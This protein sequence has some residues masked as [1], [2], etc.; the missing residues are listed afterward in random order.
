MAAVDRLGQKSAA[1]NGC[2]EAES[3]GE[4]ANGETSH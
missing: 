4:I 1:A 3:L 2:A